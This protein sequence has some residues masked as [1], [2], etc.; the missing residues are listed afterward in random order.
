MEAGPEVYRPQL[1]TQKVTAGP[2]VVVAGV[3]LVPVVRTTVGHTELGRGVS[4]FGSKRPVSLLVISPSGAEAYDMTG[5]KVSV[6]G[7]I[8][9]VP[10][11]KTMMEQP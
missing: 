11:L 8:A 5:A 9:E 6:E 2:A 7:L 10:E 4:F 1:E 3:K